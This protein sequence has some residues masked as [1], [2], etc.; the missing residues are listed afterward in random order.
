M[1]PI[2]SNWLVRR[3]E[4]K[5]QAQYEADLKEFRNEAERLI[6]GQK[7]DRQ[8]PEIIELFENA[9]RTVLDGH[10]RWSLRL[11]EDVHEQ[12]KKDGDCIIVPE[13]MF[14]RVI[15]P[16]NLVRHMSPRFDT[17]LNRIIVN[18]RGMSLCDEETELA[19]L[20]MCALDPWRFAD[21]GSRLRNSTHSIE[22]LTGIE[23]E[24]RELIGKTKL[25]LRLD[26]NGWRIF[27][28]EG[29]PVNT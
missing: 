27:A 18:K 16:V 1:F 10:W 14:G 9:E 24:W 17:R 12:V 2:I 6:D 8:L 21:D 5:A 29:V 23:I 7:I 15:H 28:L 26:E 25:E 11:L 20:G 3:E 22:M 19:A 13:A 4:R